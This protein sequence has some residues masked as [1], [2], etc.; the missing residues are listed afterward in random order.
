MERRLPKIVTTTQRSALKVK[1]KITYITID[2]LK[3]SRVR[4]VLYLSIIIL[5]L[6][7]FSDSKVETFVMRPR[8]CIARKMQHN[9]PFHFG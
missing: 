9:P 5:I 8:I 7:T 4:P 1:F 2:S 3:F 6:P